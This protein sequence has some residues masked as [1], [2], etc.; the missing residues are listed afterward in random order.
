MTRECRTDF[1]NFKKYIESYSI[2]GN[3][4]EESYVNTAKLMHK[5]YFSLLHW[6]AEFQYQKVFF[7]ESYTN[8]ED[9]LIRISEVISDIGSS[10]F[11]WINGSYKTSRVML[12][13]AI[14]NFVRAIGAIDAPDLLVEK[15]VYSLF[16][17]AKDCR[18]FKDEEFVRLSINRLHGNYKE[19][20]N[21][22]HTSSQSNMESITS[23]FD[24]PKYS[25]EKSEEAGN[26]FISVVKDILSVLCIVFNLLFHKMHHKNR[27]NVLLSIPR[28]TRPIILA[29]DHN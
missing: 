22:T 2:E 29:P 7:S 27:E 5:A 18:I 12:R 24:Y 9:V 8:N 3:L 20:C 4:K 11:N 15:N 16:D 23:L 26:V 6:F 14:E 28:Q 17:K 25:D 10:K 19:L 13:S 1:D 21:D